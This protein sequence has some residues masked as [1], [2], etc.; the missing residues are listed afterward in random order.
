MRR[1]SP[2]PAPHGPWC[3]KRFIPMMTCRDCKKPITYWECT[4][5]CKVMFDYSTTEWRRH[6][7]TA[8]STQVGQQRRTTPPSR[9]EA[10]R[11]LP[12]TIPTA[13]QALLER[14]IA[15]KPETCACPRCDVDIWLG[16]RPEW[17]MSEH[18]WNCSGPRVVT[19][20]RTASPAGSLRDQAIEDL[21][22]VAR[23]DSKR[24]VKCPWCRAEELAIAPPTRGTS[25]D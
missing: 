9:P 7:C 24:L 16:E 10:A 23:R 13:S 3:R 21:V 8:R 2:L 14:A 6:T 20:G 4:H 18:L 15:A 25:G 1:T 12:A 19:P 22:R 5:G 11:W 17:A